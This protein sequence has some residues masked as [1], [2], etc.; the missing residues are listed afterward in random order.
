MI[1]RTKLQGTPIPK[2]DEINRQWY[3]VDAKGKILGRLASEIA[4]VL[5]GK[6]KPNF[7][8][9]LD[10]GDFVIVVN[11]KHVRLTGNKLDKK[12]HRWYTGYPGG[13]RK[14][15][16]R[17]LFEKNPIKAVEHA[18]WGM[19]PH[20]RLGRKLFRKLKVYPESK[21]PHIAQK[22]EQLEIEIR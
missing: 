7:T 5:R 20:N 13:L 14:I 18:V 22:P 15:T 8:P 4:K 6:N 2:A 3:V 11:A 9:H 12:E 1:K 19:L 17:K 10:V 21:H 16:Y